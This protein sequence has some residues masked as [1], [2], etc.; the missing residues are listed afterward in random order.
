MLRERRRT[1]YR[2]ERRAL[3][4]GVATGG[5]VAVTGVAVLAIALMLTG[6]R[7]PVQGPSLVGPARSGTASSGPPLPEP[8]RVRYHA[9]RHAQDER[10]PDA[11]R[12]DDSASADP[13]SDDAE[14][15][16][17][18]DGHP[19]RPPE[20]VPDAARQPAV[21]GDR[22]ETPVPFRIKMRAR[23]RTVTPRTH[24]GQLAPSLIPNEIVA[25]VTVPGAG[26]EPARL[27]GRRF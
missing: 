22:R 4:A 1:E 10:H 14:P 17:V 27:S 7:H 5:V 21:S 26:L 12:H 2:R 24:R 3:A 19:V 13:D 8:E 16:G 11:V 25:P 15:L 9:V 20:H 18:R 6:S 23:A